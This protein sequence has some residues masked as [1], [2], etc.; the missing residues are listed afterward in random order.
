MPAMRARAVND[1]E[2]F[3]RLTH[4]IIAQHDHA[5]P[6]C[7]YIHPDMNSAPEDNEA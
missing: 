5:C 2:L 6:A 7:G 3:Q 1:H 4:T